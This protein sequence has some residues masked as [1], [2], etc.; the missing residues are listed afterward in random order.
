[1]REKKWGERG[2]VGHNI[3][4]SV[5]NKKKYASLIIKSSF[6]STALKYLLL[7]RMNIKYNVYQN[8]IKAHHCLE[9]W[10]L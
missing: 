6:V 7:F 3:R 10:K 5:T 8:F 2:A 1:M 9:L 4:F